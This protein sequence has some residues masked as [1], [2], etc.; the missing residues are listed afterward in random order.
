MVITKDD[1]LFLRGKGDESAIAKRVGEIIEQM[2]DT[3][4]EY[5]KEKLNERV[6]KMAS[7][8]AVLK[9]C[10]K[11]EINNNICLIYTD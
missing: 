11:T 8:V 9:V 3:A 1:C 2:Q 5:E 10:K 6:A 7:G 4:S